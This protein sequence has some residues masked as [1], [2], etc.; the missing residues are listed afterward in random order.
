M[1]EEAEEVKTPCCFCGAA[2]NEYELSCPQCMNHLPFC[3]ASGKYFF[4]KKTYN[5]RF[6]LPLP[7]MQIP[8]QSKLTQE[9]FKRR[10][11]MSNVRNWTEWTG[12][13]GDFKRRS[14]SIGEKIKRV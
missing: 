5:A 10:Q 8:S 2:L 4:N 14:D 13:L 1:R 3:I 7:R 12:N 11:D 6:N 9:H